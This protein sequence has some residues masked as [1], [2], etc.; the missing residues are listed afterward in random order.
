[1]YITITTTKK[2]WRWGNTSASSSEHMKSLWEPGMSEHDTVQHGSRTEQTGFYLNSRTARDRRHVSFCFILWQRGQCSLHM[3]LASKM[4]PVSPVLLNSYAS[5]KHTHVCESV[6]Y[7]IE[8]YRVFLCF[9]MNSEAYN[10]C[11]FYLYSVSS[12]REQKRSMWPLY[13]FNRPET[14]TQTHGGEYGWTQR[15]RTSCSSLRKDTIW[16][17]SSTREYFLLCVRWK[18]PHPPLPTSHFTASSH[19][20]HESNNSRYLWSCVDQNVSEVSIRYLKC[21]CVF[22]THLV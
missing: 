8:S 20:E 13:Q 17:G 18:T 9:L 14:V 15:R 2:V 5:L 12:S 11:A 16:W 22:K 19:E 10:D 3:Q 7:I 6:T 4:N 21:V 1:M